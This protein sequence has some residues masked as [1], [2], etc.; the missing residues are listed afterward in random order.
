MRLNRYFSK[1]LMLYP[2]FHL[3]REY[4]ILKHWQLAGHK[5]VVLFGGA[6][7]RIGDPSGKDQERQLKT[8]DELERLKII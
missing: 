8:G 7:G 4:M 1:K 6:T 2:L 3:S 5:P